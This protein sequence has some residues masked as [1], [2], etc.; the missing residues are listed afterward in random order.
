MFDDALREISGRL[1]RALQGG[2]LRAYGLIGGFA[3]AVHG[4]PRSTED[5]DFVVIPAT[6]DSKQLADILG[7]EF[8]PGGTDDPLRGA[9]H[10]SIPSRDSPVPVQLIVLPVRWNDV[11]TKGLRTFPVLGSQI[12]VVSWQALVLLKLYG[13]APQDL[14]DVEAVIQVQRP[15]ADDWNDLSASARSLGISAALNAFQQKSR[16]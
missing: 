4:L 9:F 15:S 12:P 2:L 6:Q 7:G 1:E 11:I 16:E 8:R 10:V 3:S 14:L 5:I 13:G